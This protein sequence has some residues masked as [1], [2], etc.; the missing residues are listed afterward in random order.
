MKKIIIYMCNSTTILEVVLPVPLD[1]AISN[2]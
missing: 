2:K 1:V